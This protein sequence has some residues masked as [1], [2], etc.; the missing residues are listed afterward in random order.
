ML[1]TSVERLRL[2]VVQS[3]IQTSTNATKGISAGLKIVGTLE[4]HTS[5]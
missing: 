5:S 1:Q 3:G 4:Q 2:A